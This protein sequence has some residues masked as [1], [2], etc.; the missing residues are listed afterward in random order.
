MSTKPTN[1][2]IWALSDTVETRTGNVN[3]VQPSAE[4]QNNG[5]L[6][7]SYALQHLNWMFN[8]LGLW[9]VFL[10]DMVANSDGSGVGL[11][12]DDHYSFILAFDKTAL[13]KFIVAIAFK[14]GAL[15]ATT[16]VIQ[17]A[18]LTLGAPQ[19]NGTIAISGATSSNIVAFSL[20]FK[21]S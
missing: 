13:S 21:L 6:D 17:S 1:T 14:S 2:V 7:G 18:T 12:K 11:T 20:N 16:Q 8:A 19:T 10:S 15:A 5:S 9:S 4:L 3:K